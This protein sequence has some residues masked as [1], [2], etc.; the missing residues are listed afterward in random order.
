MA[1]LLQRQQAG[2]AGRRARD[3]LAVLIPDS[4]HDVRYPEDLFDKPVDELIVDLDNRIIIESHLQCAGQ[5]MPLCADDEVY[6]G[7]FTRELCET[8]LRKDNDG[9]L[10][11]CLRASAR[12][13]SAHW[14]KGITLIPIFFLT[15]QG[16]YRS[17]E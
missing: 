12:I 15:R 9:W 5:E 7:P 2:R 10:A 8:K 14:L 17:V 6:F 1:P 11:F 4:L 13:P 16:M 3:S